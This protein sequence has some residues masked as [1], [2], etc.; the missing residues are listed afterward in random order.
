MRYT[1][2]DINELIELPWKKTFY[3][4]RQSRQYKIIERIS[5]S[6]NP[7]NEFL[8]DNFHKINN[9]TL[10]DPFRLLSLLE[11]LIKVKEIKG[12]IVECGSYK[13]GAGILIALA[14]DYFGI[15]KSVFLFDSFQGLPT[16]SINDSGYSKGEFKCNKVELQENIKKYQLRN[17]HI[18][19]GWFKDTISDFIQN[20]KKK[21]SFLHI[22]CDLYDSTADCL[23]KLLPLVNNEGV[24]I[25]DDFNDGGGG[26]KKAVFEAIGRNKYIFNI[27][28]APQIYFYKSQI[29]NYNIESTY[30]YQDE[31]ITYCFKD[32]FM[33]SAYIKYLDDKLGYSYKKLVLNNL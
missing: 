16:P 31:I 26:E 27:G 3:F 22:D 5:D 13:G 23:P 33:N 19:D 17:I 30:C 24:I 12:D 4:L 29:T 14:L 10:V 1:K 20:Y 6:I 2:I 18:I 7:I 8:L 32:L 11:I 15:N 28:P 25:C 21:I 9:L